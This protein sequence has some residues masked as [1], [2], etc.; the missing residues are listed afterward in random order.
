MVIRDFKYTPEDVDCRFCTEF[1]HGRCKATKSIVAALWPEEE[2][3][4]DT[5][6]S[7]VRNYI[8]TFKKAFDLVS[9]YPL[10]VSTANG[11]GV[12]IRN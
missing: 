4:W 11:Y 6:A 12:P 3:K 7:Y 2:D 8:H 5:L 10:I 1:A 9:P